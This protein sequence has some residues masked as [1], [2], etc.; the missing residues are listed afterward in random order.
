MNCW[1]VR[2]EPGRCRA[3]EAI[4]CVV[5]ASGML[6][7]WLAGVRPT[8]AALLAACALAGL[9]TALASLPGPLAALRRLEAGSRG[10]VAILR[11]GRSVPADLLP[12]TRVLPWVV[13]CRLKIGGRRIGWSV[14]QYALP[15][16]DFRRL[17]GALRASTRGP[18]C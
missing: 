8:T 13:L 12:G 14:P 9:H 3:L 4:T 17:K 16:E 7:P 15:A 6:V 2:A 5:F 11:D 18:A 10:W 1:A